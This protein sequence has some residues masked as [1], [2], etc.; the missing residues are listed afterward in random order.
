MAPGGAN[1]FT[2]GDTPKG[3]VESAGR[4][5]RDEL[6]FRNIVISMKASGRR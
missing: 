1:V 4:A 3:M 5:H 6:D 2:Y